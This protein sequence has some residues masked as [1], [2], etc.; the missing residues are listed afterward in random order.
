MKILLVVLCMAVTVAGCKKG[1]VK[2]GPSNATLIGYDL[3]KCSS[4]ACG[5][6]LVTLKNDTAKNPPPF[7]HINET[8]EQLG[9]GIGSNPKFPIDV[10]LSYRP[11]TGIFATYHYIIITHI[12]LAK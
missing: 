1:T 11:D 6:L 8:L 2:P 7:Y 10:N 3:R 5:G 12:E 9:L 4:P